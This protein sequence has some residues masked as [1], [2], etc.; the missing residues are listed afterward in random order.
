MNGVPDTRPE[1]WHPTT[2]LGGAHG[3]HVAGSVAGAVNG[4]GI[5]GVA[6]EARVADRK[7]VV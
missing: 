2:G 7:S 5:R 4:A 1:A 3:T 6:P